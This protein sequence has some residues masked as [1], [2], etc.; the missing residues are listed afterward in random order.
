M[1]LNEIAYL[2]IVKGP[3]CQI[4]HFEQRCMKVWQSTIA[5]CNLSKELRKSIF[6]FESGP[7]FIMFVMDLCNN[8]WAVDAMHFEIFHLQFTIEIF[9]VSFLAWQFFPHYSYF[10]VRFFSFSFHF[11]LFAHLFH[12]LLKNWCGFIQSLIQFMRLNLIPCIYTMKNARD[13]NSASIQ[14]LND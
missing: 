1:H 7:V 4:S 6:A 8:N 10:L 2:H 3:N 14:H 9:P 12:F 11:T 13:C 5:K